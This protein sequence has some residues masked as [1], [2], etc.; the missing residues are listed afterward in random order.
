[1]PRSARLFSLALSALL[2]GSMVAVAPSAVAETA[3]P[4][5]SSIEPAPHDRPAVK[6]PAGPKVNSESPQARVAVGPPANDSMPRRP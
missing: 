5:N 1:M 2:V 3:A 4:L 6:T